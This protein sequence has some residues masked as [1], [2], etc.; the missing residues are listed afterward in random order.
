M[1]YVVSPDW[2]HY[3][4]NACWFG[5]ICPEIGAFPY[6]YYMHILQ[7][8]IKLQNNCFKNCRYLQS[9]NEWCLM[10]M[11]FW[12]GDRVRWHWCFFFQIVLC[13]KTLDSLWSTGADPFLGEVPKAEIKGDWCRMGAE[14][15]WSRFSSCYAVHLSSHQS[16]PWI[17]SGVHLGSV[18]PS[19]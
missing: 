16:F 12:G 18:N 9:W 14:H 7:K 11:W 8:H 6:I 4:W 19:C 1:P 15:I 3:Y 10:K 13:L 5:Y 2:L 17:W